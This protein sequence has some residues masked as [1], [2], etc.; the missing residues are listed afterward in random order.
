MGLK[1]EIGKIDIADDAPDF[2]WFSATVSI[3][4]DPKLTPAGEIC[5]RMTINVSLHRDEAM[6]IGDIRRRAI[7]EARRLLRELADQFAPPDGT[8]S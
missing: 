8:P 2:P 4:D 7:D 6:S 3:F 5:R 1:T